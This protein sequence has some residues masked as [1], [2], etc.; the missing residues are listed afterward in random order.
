MPSLFLPLLLGW[1]ALWC[2]L[3]G[4]ALVRRISREEA[5]PRPIGDAFWAMTLFWV[6]IDVGIAVWALVA[7]VTETEEFRKLL[8]INGGL[9]V[10]YLVTGLVL[11]TRRASIPRGFGIAILVQ[12]GFL[13]VLDLGWWW[14]LASTGS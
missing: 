3:A 2:G 12:G 11:V 10:L 5:T 8:A 9:D 14:A 7:P 13:M 1:C 6:A 4:V